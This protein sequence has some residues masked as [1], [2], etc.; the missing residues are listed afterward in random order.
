MWVVSLKPPFSRKLLYHSWGECWELIFMSGYRPEGF[1]GPKT[2][3]A[4]NSRSVHS[5][6]IHCC[7][8]AIIISTLGLVGQPFCKALI[9]HCTILWT[10]FVSVAF[11][12]L[13]LPALCS[14]LVFHSSSSSSSLPSSQSPQSLQACVSVG[15]GV[16][17]LLVGPSRVIERLGFPTSS[18]SKWNEA[19]L[20]GYLQKMRRGGIVT[21]CYS[22]GVQRRW[23]FQVRRVNGV[24]FSNHHMVLVWICSVFVCFF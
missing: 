24:C 15:C 11:P 17:S 1:T 4:G 19:G 2:N 16:T 22:R 18:L 9:T 23:K 14:C 3:R 13:P 7:C 5:A 12:L 8:H 21:A 20:P 6:E 10:L